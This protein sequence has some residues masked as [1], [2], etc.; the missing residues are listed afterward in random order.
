MGKLK[1][2]QTW[3]NELLPE[4]L[5]YPTSTLISGPGGSGKP[6]IGFAFICDWLKAGGNVIFIA[7]QYPETKFVKTSLKR[8]YDLNVNEC[9]K[10][11]AYI[12]FD[13]GIDRWGKSNENTIKANLLKPDVLD[14]AINE[15]ENFLA[16]GGDL[17]T[18]VFASALNLLLFSPT[19][20]KLNSDKFEKLL[21]EDK[22]TTY[23]FSVSTSA[24]REDIKRWENAA[25]NLMFARMEK[26][27]KL[28]LSINKTENRKV[29]FKEVLVPIGKEILE[30]I[31]EVADNTRKRKIPELQ[32]I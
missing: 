32:K 22:K 5:P 21:S 11:I 7:L 23:M 20:K 19:Y 10:K 26:P 17:G 28:Y 13:Y 16:N 1:L 6:L 30:E 4:G 27:M 12:Q 14:E 29:P 31:K 3:L 8:L 15:I 2:H 9:P 18:M 25:D 24:F